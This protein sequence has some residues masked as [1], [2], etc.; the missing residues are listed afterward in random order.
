M[1]AFIYL[2]RLKNI[3]NMLLK[4]LHE[5]DLNPAFSSR[6]LLPLTKAQPTREETYMNGSEL[7]D[8]IGSLGHLNQCYSS[9]S[10][11]FMQV[12]SHVG[13]A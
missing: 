13:W 8:S 11:P 12:S 7:D 4:T 3:E 10:L 5:L 2:F 6:M 1:Q 9:N